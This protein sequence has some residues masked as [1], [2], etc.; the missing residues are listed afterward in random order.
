MDY[1]TTSLYC[2]LNYVSSKS[3]T[4]ILETKSQILIATTSASNS[5][6]GEAVFVVTQF[7]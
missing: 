5:S 2:D 7:I 6:I 3:T 4:T 1:D